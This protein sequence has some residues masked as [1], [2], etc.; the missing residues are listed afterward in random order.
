MIRQH[1][2]NL[3]DRVNHPLYGEGEI[4]S[5]DTNDEYLPYGIRFDKSNADF[6]DFDN[7]CEKNHGYWCN[8]CQLT[9]IEWHPKECEAVRFQIIADPAEQWYV[10][11][12]S[13]GKVISGTASW[14]LG[15]I[16]MRRFK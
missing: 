14:G 3:G 10:G 15:N 16:K 9:L 6:H 5:V 7:E 2:I 11:V 8:E 12:F 4:V 13:E 1:K